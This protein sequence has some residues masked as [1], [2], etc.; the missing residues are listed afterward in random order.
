MHQRKPLFAVRKRPL[1]I[2]ESLSF[3]TA[4]YPVNYSSPTWEIEW[5]FTSL[6]SEEL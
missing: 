6:L 2:K 5:S 1:Q 3:F 4:H